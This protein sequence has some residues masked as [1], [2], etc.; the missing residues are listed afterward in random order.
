MKESPRLT[1]ARKYLRHSMAAPLSCAV[2]AA[3]A[4]EVVGL[5]DISDGGACFSSTKSYAKGQAIELRFPVF[6]DCS[7]I[8]GAIAW[9]R[10]DKDVPGS[11][12]YGIKFADETDKAMLRLVEMICHIMTY[13]AMQEHLTGKT[14]S[15]DDAARDWL[16]KYADTFPE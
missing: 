6:K 7:V 13:R 9:T 5:L 2:R 1:E 12:R 15:A 10:P 8:P 11:H 4:E 14:M 16:S 3:N